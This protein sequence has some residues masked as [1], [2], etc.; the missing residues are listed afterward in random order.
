MLALAS[1]RTPK[2]A[3]K[4][5]ARN[6]AHEPRRPRHETRST[7]PIGPARIRAAVAS[8]SLIA[9]SLGKTSRRI[10]NHRGHHEG[11][12]GDT[13]LAEERGQKRGRQRGGR[14]C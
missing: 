6:Q 4:A 10:R 11:G 13:A 9:V 12:D 3:Q 14:G 1:M 8:G 7:R 2:N 5:A